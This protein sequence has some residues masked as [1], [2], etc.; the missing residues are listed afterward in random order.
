VAAERLVTCGLQRRSR[1]F[2]GPVISSHHQY[3]VHTRPFRRPRFLSRD[4]RRSTAAHAGNCP[5][6]TPSR[7]L[8]THNTR[9][10]MRT[11]GGDRR[12]TPPLLTRVARLSH[13]R[14]RG[15]P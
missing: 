11:I 6:S 2:D 7:C 8:R 13:V 1:L 4:N 3:G 5:L 14:Q 9:P 10:T 15:E 12:N